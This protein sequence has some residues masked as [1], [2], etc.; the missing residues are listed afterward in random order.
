M[1]APS[2]HFG[3]RAVWLRMLVGELMSMETMSFQER[4]GWTPTKHR[5]DLRRD[6]LWAGPSARLLALDVANT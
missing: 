5:E 3:T 1:P 6:L 4:Y 2:T